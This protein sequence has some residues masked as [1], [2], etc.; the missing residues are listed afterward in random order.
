MLRIRYKNRSTV[1]EHRDCALRDAVEVVLHHHNMWKRES[2]KND[3]GDYVMREVPVTDI[4]A[5]WQDGRAWD[6]TKP[7]T[8]I[9]IPG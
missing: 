3:D 1:F 4:I 7:A 6:E 8:I 2:I 9:P 5:E